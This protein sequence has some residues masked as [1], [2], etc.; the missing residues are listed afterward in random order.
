MIYGPCMDFIWFS[1][2]TLHTVSNPYDA[3]IKLP[4]YCLISGKD[5]YFVKILI[6][7]I[8]GN[9]IGYGDGIG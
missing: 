6:I 5:T 8:Y 2:G 1:Y 7:P 4:L 9:D 3:I